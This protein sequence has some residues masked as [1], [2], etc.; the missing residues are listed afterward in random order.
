MM[1]GIKE[2]SFVVILSGPLIRKR[3]LTR[4]ATIIYVSVVTFKFVKP[5]TVLGIVS[6]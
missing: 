6:T 2:L 3:S 4:D 1:N 5:E